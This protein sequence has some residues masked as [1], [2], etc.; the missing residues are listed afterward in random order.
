M[1]PAESQPYSAKPEDGWR[2]SESNLMWGVVMLLALGSALAVIALLLAG[3]HPSTLVRISA[4]IV[5]ALA[6]AL[7]GASV[8]IV[9]H[10]RLNHS[11]L[12]QVRLLLERTVDSS[13]TSPEAEIADLRT[14]WHHYY[15]TLINQRSVWRYN[16]ISFS[17]APGVGSL[18]TETTLADPRETLHRYMIE[19]AVRGPRLII[20][21]T[22]LHGREAA[23]IE[24]YPHILYKFLAV[25]AGVG[26]MQ[27]WDGDE[28]TSRCIL[29]QQPLI[30]PTEKH[31]VPDCHFSELDDAWELAFAHIQD[32]LTH[33]AEASPSTSAG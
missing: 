17:R 8:T 24:V 5:G 21:Q 11:P 22:P 32:S 1:R 4:G 27:T 3:R 29:S 14:T 20:S 25:H 6:G 23:T 26:L 31:A 10:K 30:Q 19:A 13:M 9:V 12:T 18:S 16:T 15:R 2:F 33:P 7:V 28:I